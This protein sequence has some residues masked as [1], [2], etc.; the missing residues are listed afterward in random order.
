MSSSRPFRMK[1]A[2]VSTK[3][4][5]NHQSKR[6][7]LQVVRKIE[8]R[9]LEKIDVGSITLVKWP[10]FPYWPVRI[11]QISNKSVEIIF[12]GDNNRTAKVK[13]DRIFD[14]SSNYEY[15]I[16]TLKTSQRKC[17]FKNAILETESYLQIPL[18]FSIT[19]CIDS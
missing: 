8:L 17:I 4:T 13:N 12:F 14:F 19:N 16:N 7:N 3:S 1:K 15:I 2:D 6:P 10:Y 11:L 9:Q 5:E 18:E